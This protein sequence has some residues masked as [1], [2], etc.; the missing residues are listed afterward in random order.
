M[1]YPDGKVLYTSNIKFSQLCP[2][3]TS[4]ALFS[5]YC[6]DHDW[7]FAQVPANI[8]LWIIIDYDKVREQAGISSGRIGKRQLVVIRPPFPAYM[9]YGIMHAK[10]ML[11]VTDTFLRVIVSSGNLVPYDYDEG[12]IQNILHVQDFPFLMAQHVP[13]DSNAF[14]RDLST[15]LEKLGAKDFSAIIRKYD[16][17]RIGAKRLVFSIP[18]THFLNEKTSGLE[19]LARICSDFKKPGD[20]L[21]LTAQGSSLGK[22]M[23]PWVRKFYEKA[24]N[25]ATS[26]DYDLKIVFPTESFAKAYGMEAFG[27][28]FCFK[29]NWMK[30]DC[31]GLFHKCASVSPLHTKIIVFEGSQSSFLYLGSH[32]FT[33]AAWGRYT[34]A[35]DKLMIN[36]Y[37][38]GIV[39]DGPLSDIVPKLPFKYPPEP[40]EATDLPWIQENHF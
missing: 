8:P 36:N 23:L 28:I 33:Q 13:S 37:E 35:H 26:K 32:N 2:P 7:L 10:L 39:I 19:M 24:N 30:T 25:Q 31:K 9:N 15:F 1:E 3:G 11:Y 14:Y 34:N 12:P 17:S 20:K 18:G 29:E 16:Y 4:M 21:S 27:T 6:I 38:L 5:S 22:I 40:Y